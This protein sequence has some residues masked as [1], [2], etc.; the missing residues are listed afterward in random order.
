MEYA[1]RIQ[2]NQYLP[3]PLRNMAKLTARR[4]L[5][6]DIEQSS[7][8]LSDFP[9]L[10]KHPDFEKRWQK[11]ALLVEEN[12]FVLFPGK[13]IAAFLS[14]WN[15]FR[16]EIES[17]KAAFISNDLTTIPRTVMAQWQALD[18]TFLLPVLEFEDQQFLEYLNQVLSPSS[19]NLWEDFADTIESVMDAYIHPHIQTLASMREVT[20]DSDSQV[21]NLTARMLGFNF[22]DELL[23]AFGKERVAAIIPLI[24]EAYQ[25]ASTDDFIKLIE[26]VIGSRVLMEHLYSKDYINFKTYEQMLAKKGTLL[27]EDSE[28]NDWFKT[29]HV[30]LYVEYGSARYLATK[31][32]ATLGTTL[33]EV[34]EHFLPANLVLKNFG[35]KYAINT[36]EDAPGFFFTS[37]FGQRT[38]YR[39]IKAGADAPQALPALAPPA[40]SMLFDN[41]AALDDYI[42]HFT[43]PSPSDIFA[44]WGR[45]AAN[46]W[47]PSGIPPQGEATAWRFVAAE[48]RIECTLNTTKYVGFV[49]QSTTQKYEFEAVLKST[50]TDDDHIGLVAAFMNDGTNCYGLHFVRTC[51]VTNNWNLILQ[52]GEKFTRLVAGSKDSLKGHDNAEPHKLK[53]WQTASPTKIRIVRNGDEIRAQTSP[54]GST[55]LDPTSEI[56]FNIRN[57]ARTKN[58]VGLQSYGYMASSQDK[59]SFVD[60][61]ISGE[62]EDNNLYDLENNARYY[63]DVATKQWMKQ[64]GYA[65]V[66]HVA[67]DRYFQ[68]PATQVLYYVDKNKKL[69]RLTPYV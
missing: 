64:D 17:R 63:Y 5:V 23:D 38:D 61:K 50:S 13:D 28:S 7:F 43:E 67:A 20:V 31:I 11:L 49:S 25:I 40:L 39:T 42:Q 48:N 34:I 12:A 21:I 52:E 60:V 3:N 29:T 6:A 41:K 32:N 30:N 62:F 58:L 24:G 9:I 69:K 55:V 46:E 33:L 45:F 19:A 53:G 10:D 14:D 15:L 59:A 51:Q 22:R 44:K 2:F 68:N 8:Y 57:N 26:L 27:R 36:P 66:D 1:T 16:I 47:Y 18:L 4:Q 65:F 56:V 54:F 37:E 35:L